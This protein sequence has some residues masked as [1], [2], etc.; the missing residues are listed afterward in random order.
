MLRIQL[1]QLSQAGYCE[2]KLEAEDD[3][4]SDGQ[5]TDLPLSW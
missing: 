4:A 3:H 5:M 1:Q 2:V